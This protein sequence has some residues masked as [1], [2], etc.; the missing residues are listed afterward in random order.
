MLPAIRNQ[1]IRQQTMPDHDVNYLYHRGRPLPGGGDHSREGRRRLL[2]VFLAVSAVFVL[3]VGGLWLAAR[4]SGA[5]PP[6]TVPDPEPRPPVGGVNPGQVEARR[7]DPETARRCA[8][9]EALFQQGQPLAAA[10]AA[11]GILAGLT[12]D[13]PLWS[14]AAD[15]LGRAN[16]KLLFSDIPVPERKLVYTV[17]AGDALDPIAR[18][19]RTTITVLQRANGLNPDNPT[20]RV[21]Q[22]LAIYQG[23]WAIRVSKSRFRLYL[24]EAPGRLFKVYPVGIGREGRTP[25]GKFT[26]SNKLEKPDWDSPTGRVPYGAP[27]HE[28]GS[29]WLGL[30]PAAGTDP[31]M[32]GYG[33]HGTWDPQTIG[34]ASSNGCIRLSNADVQEL[35]EIVPLKTPVEIGE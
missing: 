34:K 17:K 21:G 18:R 8:A 29:H 23:E 27:G 28:L 25:S 19:H 10:D 30:A 2:T 20:I 14:E 9:A 1:I 32:T 16:L 26:I 31:G 5:E 12:E 3:L 15:L 33:L 22:R 35:F 4:H 7:A 13:S 11:R 24:E 6:P